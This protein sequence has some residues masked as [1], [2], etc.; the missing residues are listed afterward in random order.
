M[1][2]KLFNLSL[3]KLLKIDILMQVERLTLFFVIIHSDLNSYFSLKKTQCYVVNIL[4]IHSSTRAGPES[5]MYQTLT[6][7]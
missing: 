5:T 7:V 4:W 3:F 6:T 2:L 1:A